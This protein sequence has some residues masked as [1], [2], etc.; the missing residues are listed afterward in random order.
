[1]AMLLKI[2]GLCVIAAVGY[3]GIMMLVKVFMRGLEKAKKEHF[4]N[5]KEKQNEL[6]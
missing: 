2:V 4:E 6:L 1:M 5:G 3:F